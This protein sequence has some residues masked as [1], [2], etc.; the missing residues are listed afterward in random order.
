MQEYGEIFE[1]YIG[2]SSGRI[3]LATPKDKMFSPSKFSLATLAFALISQVLGLSLEPKIRTRH[4]TEKR[5]GVVHTIFEDD[6]TGGTMDFVTNS[7]ICETTPGVNQYS[8]YFSVGS[9][10]SFHYMEQWLTNPEN[11]SMWFWF[12]EA[13]HN[14]HSAPLALW[15]NGGPG[16]SSMIGLFQVS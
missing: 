13:R 12:F 9:M 11:Q 3:S 8:G 15:V 2:A 7:G 16:C 6:A 10:A 4:Y 1:R 14:A 5:D